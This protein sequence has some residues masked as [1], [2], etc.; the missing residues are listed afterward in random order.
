MDYI[1]RNLR[2]R[3][4]PLGEPTANL[5]ESAQADNL[6]KGCIHTFNNCDY[7][8][9]VTIK[10]SHKYRMFENDFRNQFFLF[11]KIKDLIQSYSKYFCIIYEVHKCNAWIHS[12]FIFRPIFRSKV[13]KMRKEIYNLIEG[14]PLLKKS[15]KHR[16]LI[17][18]PYSYE[19][20]IE[21][22][23]KNFDDMKYYNISPH[24]KLK[25]TPLYN[26]QAQDD[27]KTQS[28]SKQTQEQL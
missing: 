8:A 1:I 24:Y 4:V 21:Y 27:H 20:Y 5:N 6:K 25:S 26:A 3:A 23:F 18:K 2:L 16:I 17:E 14:H 9:T 28:Q 15:Y 19:N 7:V 22:M 11:T 12:H 10:G 13:S